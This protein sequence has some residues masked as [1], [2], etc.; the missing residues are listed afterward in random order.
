[1]LDYSS[2]RINSIRQKLELAN[3]RPY[4][5][6]F[7]GGTGAGK[8]TTLNTI[9]NK[10]VAKVGTGVD[11][12][13]MELGDYSLS[14]WLRIWDSPG[15]GDGYYQDIEHKK[16]IIE[17]LN[18]TYVLDNRKYRFIDFVVVI[19]DGSGRDLGTTRT[20]FNEVLIPNISS[21]RVIIAI[22]QADCAQKGRNW[23]FDYSRPKPQ[24]QRYLEQFATSIQ[25]RIYQDTGKRVKRPV[26]Y[27][28]EYGYN[29]CAFLDSII[30][31][32][33]STRRFFSQ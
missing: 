9:F 21:E 31:N 10:T 5:V 30:D 1:M 33:P 12:E 4:D 25:N 2:Y 14:D 29:I 15:L 32:L 7:T 6:L 26:Y 23:D 18:S 24:L 3:F 28:A 16:K 19:V 8:S 13:T 17:L 20:L 22:N 27:S 11:P